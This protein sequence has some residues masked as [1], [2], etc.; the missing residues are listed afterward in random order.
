MD[1]KWLKLC[2]FDVL[3]VFL[4]VLHSVYNKVI[5]LHVWDTY[6]SVPFLNAELNPI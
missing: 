2:S 1:P 5:M 3:D 6:I 4:I